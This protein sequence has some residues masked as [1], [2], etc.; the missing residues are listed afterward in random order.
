[1]S[2]NVITKDLLEQNDIGESAECEA[3]ECGAQSV[4]K[5]RVPWMEFAEGEKDKVRAIAGEKST[6]R[7]NEYFMYT[8]NGR[9]L[10][11]NTNWCGAFVSW[12]FA[13]DGYDYKYAYPK[14]FSNSNESSKNR[15]IPEFSCRAV[16]W[17]QEGSNKTEVWKKIKKPVYGAVAVRENKQGIKID[18]KEN[19]GS[20]GHIT[21]VLGESEDGKYFHCLGGNQ[22]GS[23]GA[24]CVTVSKYP[25]KKDGRDYF[26]WFLI[27]PDYELT[28]QDILP[29][30]KDDSSLLMGNDENSRN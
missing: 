27:P 18:G 24:R 19:F 2:G 13:M 11:D 20:D 30:L 8:T 10:N 29:K 16:M 23:K 25:Q 3:K 4:E 6:A 22:G 5:K 17:T 21:F 1:M 14:V 9:N 15:R 7:I 12:C 28:E 26:S